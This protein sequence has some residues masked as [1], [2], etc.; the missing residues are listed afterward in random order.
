MRSCASAAGIEVESDPIFLFEKTEMPLGL[1][2][3]GPYGLNGLLYG[4]LIL[5]PSNTAKNINYF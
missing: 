5:F 2:D 1:S 3:L 4:N